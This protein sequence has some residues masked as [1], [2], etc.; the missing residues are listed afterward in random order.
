MIF[1]QMPRYLHQKLKRAGAVYTIYEGA[2]E[3]PSPDTLLTARLVC[4]WSVSHEVI[5]QFVALA[6]SGDP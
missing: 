5:D 2:L 4:D 1:F 6:A 3:G